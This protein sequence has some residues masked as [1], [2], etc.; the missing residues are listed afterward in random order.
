M[1]YQIIGLTLPRVFVYAGL[2]P[3][4]AHEAALGPSVRPGRN[5]EESALELCQ[6][7]GAAQSNPAGVSETKRYCVRPGHRSGGR[8][9]KNPGI[10]Q[11][12][13][14]AIGVKSKNGVIFFAVNGLVRSVQ[15][16]YALRAGG[17]FRLSGCR[18]TP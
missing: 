13:A 5:P 18:Q 16:Q 1:F 10:A 6:R 14:V 9:T 12:E 3:T 7:V 4:V 11:S 17:T 15:E 2:L 8:P